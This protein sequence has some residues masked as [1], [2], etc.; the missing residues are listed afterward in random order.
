MSP[1]A[2]VLIRH[3]LYPTRHS[4]CNQCADPHDRLRMGLEFMLTDLSR[5]SAY[6]FAAALLDVDVN[7]WLLETRAYTSAQGAIL[8]L[9]AAP[10]TDIWIAMPDLLKGK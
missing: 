4:A 5:Y 3:V 6:P 8:P 2:L 1:I 9:A 10:I 7:P